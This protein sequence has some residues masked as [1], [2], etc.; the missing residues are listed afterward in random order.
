MNKFVIYTAV[1]GNYDEILQPQVI[2]DR[3]DYVLFSNEI[4]EKQIGVWQVRPITYVNDIQTKIARYVKTHP[5]ELLPEYDISVW[6]DANIQIASSDFYLRVCELSDNKTI[7]STVKHPKLTCIYQEMLVMVYGR[8]EKESVVVDWGHFLRKEN[9]PRDNGI[10]ET[11]VLF[12]NHSV[13]AIKDFDEQ[14]WWCID[15]YSRRDQLSFNYVLW[16]LKL[17]FE[18]FFE[19]GITVRNSRMVNYEEIH[20]NETKKW[21]NLGK[22]EAWLGRY[23]SHNRSRSDQI[24]RLY[25]WIYGTR[26]PHFWTFVFGQLFRVKDIIVRRFSKN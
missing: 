2:D 20:S 21:I 4:E 16:K 17:Q 23:V 9:Y 14:W 7:L 6:M 11:G 10:V 25:Y 15:N 22:W 24:E 19:N 26:F 13:P 18:P 8:Y 3:F 1:I 12:R 5:E